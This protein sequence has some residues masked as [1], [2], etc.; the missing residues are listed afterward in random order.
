MLMFII[1]MEAL[2]R[3]SWTGCPWEL[4]YKDDLVIIAEILSELVEKFHLWKSNIE[5]KVLRVNV[6]KA[7]FMPNAHSAP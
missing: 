5:S 1:F 4:L 3:R 2:S 6:S 7:K